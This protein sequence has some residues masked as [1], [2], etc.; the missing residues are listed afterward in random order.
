[1]TLTEIFLI[2]VLHWVGDFWFQSDKQAK[3]KS[4][5]MRDLVSHTF[6]Y[7]FVWLCC[8]FGLCIYYQVN[9]LFSLY[10]ALI[11]FT[12][13]T[14]Q[15]YFTSRLNSRLYQQGKNHEFFI[16]LGGDQLL[17]YVQLFLTYYL[18]FK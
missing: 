11:T 9:P 12:A 2:L 10:F 6:S 14:I 5:N 8:M 3:G 1:M 4:K 17:H 13:H 15:D 16:A 18:L 7:S